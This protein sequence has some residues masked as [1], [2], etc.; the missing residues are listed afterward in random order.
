MPRLLITYDYP[1][2]KLER[3]S[4][5]I[6]DAIRNNSEDFNGTCLSRTDSG[7]SLVTD[8]PIG[9]LVISYLCLPPMAKRSRPILSRS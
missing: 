1:V 3:I 2:Q 4:I 5:Y 9:N 6:D 8:I 7:E